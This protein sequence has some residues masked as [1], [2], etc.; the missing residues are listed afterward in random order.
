MV[1]Y[2]Y[3]ISDIGSYQI[4]DKYK[5][6]TGK[7]MPGMIAWRPGHVAIVIDKEEHIAEMKSR[8]DD[9]KRSRTI[10]S[11]GMQKILYD[12]NVNYEAVQTI[13]WHFEAEDLQWYAY[14]EKDG[15]YY[16]GTWADIDGKRFYFDG[17]GYSSAGLKM[18]D[19]NYYYF[20]ESGMLVTDSEGRLS[21]WRTT[22][23]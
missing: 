23:T 13:G 14:G 21:L 5:E 20:S 22:T 15:E 9:F 12:K 18:I 1:C 6:W 7:A 17:S 4:K 10:K 11:A 2:C 8:E 3:G 16:K 19:G